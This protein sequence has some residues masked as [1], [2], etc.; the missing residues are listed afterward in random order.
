[1]KTIH[2]NWT[3]LGKQLL[4]YAQRISDGSGFIVDAS[5]LFMIPA[6]LLQ[7]NQN[8]SKVSLCLPSG[9][10]SPRSYFVHVKGLAS[11]SRHTCS[12]GF[13]QAS[14][15]L[16]EHIKSSN[17]YTWTAS[18][19]PTSRFVVHYQYNHSS[20]LR[21]SQWRITSENSTQSNYPSINT[22]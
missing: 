15:G 5:P 9:L 14:S 1:M 2:W 11:I 6:M 19:K 3:V 16:Q 18:K 8:T 4:Q 7:H 22:W 13:D 10:R 21:D 20:I 12:G 17:C